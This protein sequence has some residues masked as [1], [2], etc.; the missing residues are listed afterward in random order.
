VKYISKSS[1]A[2]SGVYDATDDLMN[3]AKPSENPRADILL[4][5]EMNL[6]MK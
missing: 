2:C 1:I 5:F 6:T 3:F 4:S